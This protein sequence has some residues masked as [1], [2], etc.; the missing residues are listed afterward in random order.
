MAG[1]VAAILVGL[2]RAP[3]GC[4]PGNPDHT[5]HPQQPTGCGRQLQHGAGQSRPPAADLRALAEQARAHLEEAATTLRRLRGITRLHEATQDALW[6]RRGG[7]RCPAPPQQQDTCLRPGWLFLAARSVPGRPRP[8]RPHNRVCAPGRRHAARDKPP[9][10]RQREPGRRIHGSYLDHADRTGCR[11]RF[12]RCDDLLPGRSAWTAAADRDAARRVA[13]LPC[14][15]RL[16]RRGRL[17]PLR[18][19]HRQSGQ[20]REQGQPRVHQARRATTRNSPDFNADEAIW[21]WVRAEVTANTCFGTKARVREKVGALFQG[22]GARTDEVKRCCRTILQTKAD[23]TILQ[24]KADV[25][26]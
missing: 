20:R 7:T 19:Q 9:A 26:G 6:V 4:A 3:G 13:P 18:F 24:T 5:A 16:A 2:E 15:V 8:A 11:A 23:V 10:R 12:R 25:G 17:A 14:A 1:V 21:G 22:L